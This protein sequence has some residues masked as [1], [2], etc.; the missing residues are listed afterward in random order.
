MAIPRYST[1]SPSVPSA[2][3]LPLSH[4]SYML[5][6][7]QKCMFS[8][9]E[10]V[11][12]LKPVSCP[13]VYAVHVLFSL[14]WIV[15]DLE[16]R[17]PS[18]LVTGTL[19][20]SIT[21]TFQSEGSEVKTPPQ[22]S[23]M[24]GHVQL[25]A[26]MSQD[27]CISTEDDNTP[28]VSLRGVVGEDNA[29]SQPDD[30]IPI[31]MGTKKDVSQDTMVA[32]PPSPLEA[33][34]TSLPEATPSPVMASFSLGRQASDPLMPNMIRQVLYGSTQ[35][36]GPGSRGNSLQRHHSLFSKGSLERPHDATTRHASSVLVK[37]VHSQ[38]SDML[39]PRMS[40]GGV[41]RVHVTK[42]CVCTCRL[43]TAP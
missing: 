22:P 24:P 25:H 3:P 12:V 42:V 7:T 21:C 36:V 14:S 31:V 32:T 10:H 20:F 15:L 16:K 17:L 30:I 43:G 37:G 4:N 5:R 6:I 19:S 33:A 8:V 18:D 35:R 38:P 29:H 23:H 1:Y 34:P 41:L 40:G 9:L 2:P 27:S 26:S 13:C 11:V 39:P 28:L